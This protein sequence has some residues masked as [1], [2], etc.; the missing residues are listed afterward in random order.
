MLCGEV[1]WH[2]LIFNNTSL[3]KGRRASEYHAEAHQH[4]HTQTQTHTRK[5]TH[6]HTH[7]HTHAHA[8]THTHMHMHTHTHRHVCSSRHASRH[9]AAQK[10]VRGQRMKASSSAQFRV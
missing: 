1:C 10:D 7:T 9:G 6:T 2:M 3:V 4:T 5:H 8:H